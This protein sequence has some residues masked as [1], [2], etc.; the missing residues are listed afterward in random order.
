MRIFADKLADNL[1]RQRQPVYLLFGNEPLLIQES[2]DAIL[3]AAKTAGFN[4]K[5]NFT[6]DASLDW[7]DVFEC[8]NALSLF[9]NQQIIE[10]EIPESG[11]NAAAAKQL[12]ELSNQLNP[13]ILLLIIGQKLT[14]AQENSKWFKS[15][16]QLGVWVSCLT[17][18]IQRLPQFIQTRCR[19]L[20]LVPDPEALQMLAQWHEGNLLALKQSL[21]KLALLYPDGQLSLLRVEEA[22]SRHN[23]YTP[24]QWIDALLAGKPNRSQRILRQLELEGIEPVILLRTFQRELTLVMTLKSESSSMP[25]GQVFDKHR[26]WQ[27]KRPLYNSAVQ[28][29]SIQQIRQLFTLLSKIE[30]AIKTQYENSNWPLISQLSL[31]FCSVKPLA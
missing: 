21:D 3:M 23:H 22:L 24:F 1:K 15:L 8:C 11:V 27:T 28:R 19:Q 30:I 4:E 6:V 7:G 25:I 20:N 16:N 31:E 17:P 14:R 13:D 9:S 12:I 5:Y 29:L 10:L 26:I 2:R 18:D